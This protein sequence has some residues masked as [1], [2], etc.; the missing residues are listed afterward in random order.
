[1]RPGITDFRFVEFVSLDEVVG[2]ENADGYILGMEF[3]LPWYYV[4]MTCLASKKDCNVDKRR[5]C[6]LKLNE[7]YLENRRLIE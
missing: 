2:E 7:Y 3:S 1:M 4:K 6:M 5:G